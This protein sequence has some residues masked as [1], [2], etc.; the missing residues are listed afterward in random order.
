MKYIPLIISIFCAVSSFVTW[1]MSESDQV[2]F[3]ALA[4]AWFAYARVEFQ[5]I[6]IDALAK[7]VL[8]L[9]SEPSTQEY[10]K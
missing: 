3:L 6:R 1:L 4:V 5:E 7:A 2:G 8:F 10:H 9:L